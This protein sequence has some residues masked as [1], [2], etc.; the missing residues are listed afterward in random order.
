M[1]EQ[2]SKWLNITF[3]VHFFIII[4]FGLVLL[5][6]VEGYRDF[7]A[8]P[9]LDPVIGRVLGAAFIGFAASSLLAW[10]ETEWIKVKI[11]VQMEIVW[12][13]IG[14][15]TLFVSLFV[16]SFEALPLFTWVTIILLFFFLIVFIWF[17]F[18]HER[19]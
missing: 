14:G 3:L 4:I 19:K 7:I 6:F 12:C 11:I 1:A 10:R 16:P 8:W 17:Y 5:I 9:Y 2:I 15:I 13:A 18:Q